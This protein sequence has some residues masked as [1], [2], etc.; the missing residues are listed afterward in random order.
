MN[1]RVTQ[2]QRQETFQLK[3]FAR[4]ASDQVAIR[5]DCPS[6]ARTIP[7]RLNSRSRSKKRENNVNKLFKGARDSDR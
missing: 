7:H 6:S 2:I 3:G 1:K 5:D 4:R